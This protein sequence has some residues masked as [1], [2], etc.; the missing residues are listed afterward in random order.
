MSSR[1]LFVE[2]DL[3]YLRCDAGIMVL[4]EYTYSIVDVHG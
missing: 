3:F 2:S 1:A 4:G